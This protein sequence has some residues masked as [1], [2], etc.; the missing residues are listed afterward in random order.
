VSQLIFFF[1]EFLLYL[2]LQSKHK[3]S[4]L[5]NLK[6]TQKNPVFLDD[7]DMDIDNM[8]FPLPT[9][10]PSSS[11]SRP[12]VPSGM[13]GLGGLGG[14][15]DMGG[16]PDMAQLQKMMEGMGAGGFGGD[17]MRPG[18]APA[19]ASRDPGF[20]SVAS[21]PSGKT[22]QMHPDEYKE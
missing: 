11:S 9:D 13:G 2:K 16:M 20:V 7:E 8:D 17:A 19:A 1:C 15:G 14:M 10:G 12:N 6:K 21:H 18:A 4:M 22:R 3:M 5:N